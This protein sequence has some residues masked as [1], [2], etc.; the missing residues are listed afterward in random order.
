MSETTTDTTPAAGTLRRTWVLNC[1]VCQHE[2]RL[3]AGKPHTEY[4]AQGF[5]QVPGLG[6]VC[7]ACLP[8]LIK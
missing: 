2:T 4:Y 1:G 8:T 3:E 6:W 5:K 7:P